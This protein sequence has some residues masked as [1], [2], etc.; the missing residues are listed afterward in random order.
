MSTAATTGSAGRGTRGLA[1]LVAVVALWQVREAVGF[2]FVEHDDGINIVFNPHL[3]PWSRD[4][5]AWAFSDLETMRRYVPLGWLGLA[6]VFGFSGLSPVGYHAVNVALHALNSALVFVLLRVLVRRFGREDSEGWGEVAALVGALSWAWHPLRAETVGWASGLLY[7]QSG[8][9]ALLSVLAYLRAWAP[10]AGRGRWVLLAT[11]LY[12]AAVLTY[13]MCLG[14]LGVF[15]L[16]DVAHGPERHGVRRGTLAREKLLLAL[17][18]VAALAVTFWASHRAPHYWT[19]PPGLAEFGLGARLLQGG[20]AWAYFLVK[21]WWPVGLTPV[22]TALVD[23]GA[24][25]P[26][27]IAGLIGVVAGSVF[28]F[29]CWQRWRGAALLWA[30]YACLLGPMLG[31]TERPYFPADRYHYLAGVVLAAA[32]ALGVVRCPNR[33]R[34]G[35]AGVAGGGLILLA[36]AQQ[37]QLRI[38]ANTDALMQRIV[39]QAG[40]EEVRREYGQRWVRFHAHRG[41]G[42]QAATVA[43][44][45]G[46]AVP[47]EGRAPITVPA[48]AA[49]HMRLAMDFLRDERRVEAHVHFRAALELAPDWSEAAHN[50]ALLHVREGRAA[51]ALHLYLRSGRG[52]GAPV[53]DGARQRLLLLIAEAFSAAQRPR[54]ALRVA[55]LAARQGG[56]QT[57]PALA[58]ILEARLARY[59]AAAGGR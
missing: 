25:R 42:A 50:W 59:R 24:I 29:G 44:K 34:A 28:L 32:L 35:V 3:G 33:W 6:G 39:A 12:A 48:A 31:F 58:E 13:P 41:R 4:T 7:G 51:E 47:S 46:I 1:W 2:D 23:A 11:L 16:L 52:R 9:L 43:A 53:P 17:P 30:A 57:E 8:C 40:N 18:F 19:Q 37:R 49:L 5:V 27:A 36:V 22:P 54:L 38:W 55:E 26:L 15:V 21:P 45:V 20:A 10:G 56:G 14:L